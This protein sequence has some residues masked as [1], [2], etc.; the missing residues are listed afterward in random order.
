M[1]AAESS[2]YAALPACAVLSLSPASTP[3]RPVVIFC[4]SAEKE[5]KKDHMRKVLY[6][7]TADVPITTVRSI[8]KMQ[9]LEAARRHTRS[10]GVKRRTSGAS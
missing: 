4:P 1:L 8:G 3:A 2:M 7:S 5:R 10:S 6:A 9:A